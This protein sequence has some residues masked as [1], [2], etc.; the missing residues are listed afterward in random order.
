MY[1]RFIWYLKSRQFHTSRIKNLFSLYSQREYQRG[2]SFMEVGSRE[3][4]VPKVVNPRFLLNFTDFN[5][6][7]ET[8]QA[9]CKGEAWDG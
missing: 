8:Q 6:V 7:Y 2:F 3:P 5:G 4:Q 9:S 1:D